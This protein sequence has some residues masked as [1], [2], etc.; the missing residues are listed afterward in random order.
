MKLDRKMMKAIDLAGDG[1]SIC[2]DP[3]DIRVS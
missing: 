1:V 3:C 2:V